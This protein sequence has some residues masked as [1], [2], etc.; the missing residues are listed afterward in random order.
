MKTRTTITR[1]LAHLLFVAAFAFVL[2]NVFADGTV[3]GVTSIQY[4]STRAIDGGN[5]TANDGDCANT[6]DRGDIMDFDA[7][8]APNTAALD[9]DQWHFAW[10]VDSSFDLNAITGDFFGNPATERVAWLIGIELFCDG[11]PTLDMST[12]GAWQRNFSWNVD[13][14]IALFPNADGT[15]L[16]GQ[17]WQNDGSN[18]RSLV[19]G[20]PSFTAQ[21]TVVGIR[22][23]IEVALPNDTDVPAALRDNSSICLR[24]LSAGDD[25]AENVYDSLPQLCGND[26]ANTTCPGAFID[27]TGACMINTA[28][29]CNPTTEPT[30]PGATNTRQC[31]SNPDIQEI[32]TIENNLTCPGPF[33]IPINTVAEAEYTVLSEDRFSGPYT[34][35]SPDNSDFIGES[36]AR[37][38]FDGTTVRNIE[39]EYGVH[40]DIAKLQVHGDDRYMYVILQGPTAMG[41]GAS[42][43]DRMNAYIPIDVDWVTSSHTEGSLLDVDGD[44]T[45]PNFRRVNFRGWHPD[46]VIEIEWRE[47]ANLYAATGDGVW[48]TVNNF[49]YAPGT[50]TAIAPVAMYY[51]SDP[52]NGNY[53]LAIPWTFLGRTANNPPANTE[54]VKFGAYTTGDT[55][56]EVDG[57]PGLDDWDVADQAPGIGQ[58]C[59]GLG[60]DER[61]GDD[62]FDTDEPGSTN[63][64]SDGTPWVGNTEA[65]SPNLEHQP[66]TDKTALEV[67]TIE[68]YFVFKLDCTPANCDTLS[69]TCP[70]DVTLECGAS[71]PAVIT[72]Q[73]GW[74]AASGSITISDCCT[75]SLTFTN[76]D[77]NLGGNDCSNDPYVFDR[78]YTATDDCGNTAVCTQTISFVDSLAPT[79]TTPGNVTI[80]C[81]ESTATSNTGTGTATDDCHSFTVTFSDTVANGTCAQE[82]T[83]TR[84]WTAAD[85]CGN[86]TNNTQ[87]ISIQDDVAPTINCPANVTVDCNASTAPGNTGTATANDSCD[88]SVTPTYSDSAVQGTCPQEQVIT[89]TWAATDDCGNTTNCMQ[90]ISVQDNTPPTLTCPIN[91]TI[92]CTESTAPANTGSASANDTCDTFVN[93]TFGDSAAAG[94][95]PQEQVITRTWSVMDDCGNSTN[96]QQTITV[97]DNAPPTITCPNNITIECTASTAPGNTGAATANDA[98]D[99][100]VTP[101]FTDNSTP[102]TCS[103]EEVITRTWTATDDCGNSTNCVQTIT[104]DDS[105]APAILDC[106]TDMTVSGDVNCEYDLPDFTGRNTSDNCGSVTVTQLPVPGTTLSG[107]GVFTVTLTASDDCNSS[108]CT[109]S[110]TINCPGASI[111][112]EKAT[113]GEDA[114]LAGDAVR[115]PVGDPVTWTYVIRNTGDVNLSNII[116]TD[117]NGTPGNTADDWTIPSLDC[118]VP[119][120]GPLAPNGVITCTAIRTGGATA[121]LYGNIAD[122]VGTPPAGPN[123]IDEDPSHHTG[124]LELGDFVWNDINQDGEQQ[125]SEPVISNVVV[126]LRSGAGTFIT[127]TTTSGS[128]L[129]L[130]TDLDPGNYIVEFDT[131]AGFVHTL[132]DNVADGIDSDVNP[133]NNQTTNI[134]LSTT[135][136][137]TWDAGYF[138]SQPDIDIEKA[139]NTED[140]DLAGD[141]VRVPVGNAVTWTYVIQN[142]GN[143]PLTNIIA[144]D[145]NGTPGS[146]GDDWTLT[147]ADCD[148]SLAG[149]LATNGTITC[150]VIK[151]GGATAGLYGN[152]VDVIGTPPAGT[153]PTDEDPSHHTG[154]LELGDFVWNDINQ[155]GD[156]DSEPGIDGVLVTLRNSAG[157]FI[158]STNT[159][160]GG[161]YVF[162]DLDPGSYLV[163]FAT[164]SGFIHTFQDNAPDGVDSDVNPANNRTMT[165]NLTTTNDYTWDAGY[166]QSGPGIDIEKA[167]NGEDAD[168]AG[169]AVRVPVGNAVTWT[170]VIRNTGN[171]PLTNI[172]ATDDNG[173]PANIADDWTLTN[174]DCDASLAGPLDTNEVITCTV[175]K[176]GG[177]TAGLYGNIVDVIGT[178][179]TGTPP[180]DEDPSHHTGTLELGDYVWN[181]VNQNGDQDSEPGISGVLVTL[182]NGSGAFLASTNTSPSGIY[183]FSDLNPGNYIVEFATP[184]G[185]VH[186]TQD[187]AL[188]GVDSD[189]NPANNR[190]TTISL[191][192]T[193]DYTWDAGYFTSG[194]DIDIEKAT[195][196]EDA[197]L[198]A[199]A[200]RVPAGDPV[201]WTYVIRNTGNV[202]LTNIIATDDN[203]TPANMTDDW[204]LTNA[205]CDLP[206]A[207]P[208][209]PNG[210]ITCTVS[211]PGGATAG[212]YGNTVNVTGTPPAGTPP[213]DE[214]PSHFTGTLEIGDRV[215]HDLDEDGRQD[216]GE[217]GI[218]QVLVTLR[219]SGSNFVA[220]IQTTPSGFYI[221]TDLDPDDYIVEFETPTGFV[222]SPQDNAPDGVDSD[223]NPLNNRTTIID[224]TTTNEYT[225]DAGYFEAQPDV[226]VEKLTNGEDADLAADAV[227]VS[228]GNPVTWTY[229]I[230]NTG[231]VPLTNI[232]ATDDNGT[233]GSTSDDWTLTNADCDASL[234]GPLVPG[235]MITCS[236][237]APAGADAGL[238]GNIVDV[239]G[240]PPTGTPPTDEDP[241]HYTGTLELGDLVWNDVNP[242]G[243]HEAGEP[244][245]GNILVT[246]RDGGGAFITSTNT[247]PSG[248]YVFS[249]L[250]PGDYI[251]EFD[252]PTGFVHTLQNNT[253][254]DRDSDVSPINNRTTTITLVDDNDYTWDAGYFR[255][256]PGIDIEKSTNG[257][258]ADLPGDAVGVPVGDSVTW[259]YVIRNT[260][261]VPL[262]NIIATD[263]NGTPGNTADDFMLS[264]ANCD[265]SL[266]GPLNPGG[267]ITCTFDAIGGATAGLYGNIA[268]V[269]GT[270]PTGTPP[271]D[272]DPS[273]Y[274]G[275]LELG[276]RVWHDINENGRQDG[277]EPGIPNVT[278]ILRDSSGGFITNTPTSPTGYYLFTGLDPANY[279]VE[280]TTPAGYVHTAQD[281][282]L[283]HLDS[284]VNPLNDRTSTVS[285]VSEDDYTVDAGYFLSQPEIDVEK[286]TNGNDAD[287]PA[288]ADRIPTGDSVTWTYEVT[289]D[290][291]VPLTNIILTDDNGTPGN[292]ADD[293][294]LSNA[295]CDASL[296]GPLNPDDSITCTFDAIGGA[297]PGLYG[298]TITA[299]GTPP[300]GTPPEDEDPSHYFGTVELGDLVWN[301][302]NQNGRQ[303]GGEPGIGDV[304]VILR[305]DNGDFITSMQTAPSG[306]Y[307]FTD[308]DPAEYIVEFVTPAGFFPTVRNNALDHRDSDPNPLT[309]EVIVEVVD[310]NDYTIDAG[311]YPGVPDIDIE[312]LTNGEDADDPADAPKVRAGD[313]ITWTYV[314]QNTGSVPL[315]NITA[316][317]DNG[318]PG[319]TS[320]DWTLANANCDKSLAGP[321]NP[322]EIITCS[323]DKVGGA[324]VG[325]YG[326]IVDVEG[327][328]PSGD[329]PTD[330]DPS[331]YVGTLELGDRVW[332]DTNENGRQDG[333][334]VGIPGVTVI[335]RDSSGIYL[336]EQ[337]TSP[338]GYYLFDGLDPDS[339]ILE[340]ITPTGYVHTSQDNAG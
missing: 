167:T 305:D 228:L 165:I 179:P 158:S 330:E 93:P 37:Q 130:F 189:V 113:N 85:D 277:G 284:D 35:G 194:P 128:G 238:Y 20:V 42:G 91:V 99:I 285:L 237:V 319:N 320:D 172:I 307:L 115:V 198:A 101:T 210:T 54:E 88:N 30:A 227:R 3:D 160:G 202:P 87:T 151:T 261:N 273:H 62:P 199:D 11:A 39:G 301:D 265:M 44:Q 106:P 92:D 255:S 31:L 259:T 116:V 168:L 254:D 327:T 292:T 249:D 69:I 5:D 10:T 271:T 49:N 312:K 94:T 183:V 224:L 316:V 250:E 230:Q 184:A 147:D 114:D 215:W 323:V 248:M 66:A 232:V 293:F 326:N 294:T 24:I 170:Y 208:L 27:Y 218:N 221:F 336:D 121:G 157:G 125:G 200:V 6:A 83:I 188:D 146:A 68:E 241:S 74:V 126:T 19:P 313:S 286:A 119:L 314:I 295:N 239:T 282:A 109:F 180:T 163:E 137:Y 161:L 340:F 213:T 315:T 96:C 236:V 166:F 329:K 175:V 75:N 222:H 171:V 79:L 278:V 55:N 270:P 242:N 84:T 279:I 148:A 47:G 53:E 291:N 136:D 280:F 120:A 103:Q 178:P 13:Y 306:Y 281:N 14:F 288:A 212:L 302:I 289:N 217:P 154:T 8:S 328:P 324:T 97:Q 100:S 52:A 131:P 29:N 331:H 105:S 304:T 209:A 143:V 46:F 260:G 95:C 162:P 197:D 308:L 32:V 41:D 159:S 257:E 9:D 174:A 70:P 16:N 107:P 127:S 51:D 196:G 322:G 112:I 287:T 247:S 65:F 234:A 17:L 310:D 145:D 309:G 28:P 229:I 63:N 235:G 108:N 38:W 266:A 48:G 226:D 204:T 40:G 325:P 118:D 150:S 122:V 45:A 123:V 186:T 90:T 203:G 274:M 104:V 181:D 258:D 139:T 317:D 219:D 191:T 244:G 140:A 21:S 283:D 231:N 56:L 211:K 187:N 2:G 36:S 77:N 177:A 58:G 318:T 102:G 76:V 246:L 98:C 185:F 252:T 142:T 192:T 50:N 263:D 144:T 80:Q 43:T 59:N 86:S 267:V 129:Y 220:S 132:L 333:G 223:V 110:I 23:F 173:T 298:N 321:L 124:T 272:E 253:T 57:Q 72:N 138:L 297:I 4:G 207:G 71:L 133:A 141:A 245:I 311:F 155:N 1:K 339:Y 182:R 156:Q 149:P 256:G 34:G 73:T 81:T 335:L 276:D 332:I 201:T 7:Y 214:D 240:T 268:D 225:W 134:T 195:N 60:C 190:T 300:T 251:V 206:L 89:R 264:N 117:D 26:G 18:N 337:E 216:T 299:T 61:I 269:T 67:D 153:P 164:P 12:A 338:T 169:D 176:S 78:V 205:D 111:D 25:D 64:Q 243:I 334:E 193:N 296:A 15:T 135:N 22:R 33:G 233:P 290:G 152:T 275:T 82:R 262:T 303:D